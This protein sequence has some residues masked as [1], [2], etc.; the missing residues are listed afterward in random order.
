MRG[1]VGRCGV[2]PAR[3]TGNWRI[4]QRLRTF[5]YLAGTLMPEQEP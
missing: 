1:L 2:P 4:G 5:E 3:L